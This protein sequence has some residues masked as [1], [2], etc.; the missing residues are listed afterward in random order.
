MSTSS[1]QIAYENSSYMV[2]VNS[3]DRIRICCTGEIDSYRICIIILT[4]SK[5]INLTLN[6]HMLMGRNNLFINSNAILNR[7]AL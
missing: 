5:S 6:A 1:N 7:D 4:K 2:D 3:C